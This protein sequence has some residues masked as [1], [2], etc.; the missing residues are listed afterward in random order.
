MSRRQAVVKLGN[1]VL[2]KLEAPFKPNATAAAFAAPAWA[3]IF[4]QVQALFVAFK[5]GLPNTVARGG[6]A[7]APLAANSNL[8]L[9]DLVFGHTTLVADSIPAALAKVVLTPLALAV[10]RYKH[11][12]DRSTGQWAKE[13]DDA[14]DLALTEFKTANA[15]FV[16]Q[17]VGLDRA[18]KAAKSYLKTSLKL[19]DSFVFTG[20]SGE[21]CNLAAKSFF[22]D[23]AD[24][25]GSLFGPDGKGRK[26]SRSRSSSRKSFCSNKSRSRS[27]SRS[28]SRKRKSKRRSYRRTGC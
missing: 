8:A 23:D 13:V 28:S 18:E 1:W 20:K 2:G 9:N 3:D 6:N 11:G 17:G 25:L 24:R 15:A 12:N 10:E 4:P 14:V 16:A 7:A 5:T 19:M 22:K 26:R 27:R 21:R